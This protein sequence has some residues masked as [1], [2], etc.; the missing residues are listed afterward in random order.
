MS[1]SSAC[2]TST[3]GSPSES[4]SR[5]TML[6][7]ADSFPNFSETFIADHVKLMSEAGWSVTLLVRQLHPGFSEAAA[8]LGD[9][10]IVQVAPPTL[11]AYGQALSWMARNPWC[12]ANTLMWRCALHG[13]RLAAS[14]VP[15]QQWDVVHAH[16]G[17]NGVSALIA[18]TKWLERLTVNFH[19][20]DVT[21]V[22]TRHGWAAY[23][24]VL[25]RCHAVAHST[26][27]E[28]RLKNATELQVHPVTMGVDLTRFEPPH[29]ALCWPRPLR[30]LCVGRLTSQKGHN[31]AID[32][33]HWLREHHPEF[34]AQLTI[35]GDGPERCHLESQA[36][37]L[38]VAE[39]VGILKARPNVDMPK[40]YS[41]MDILLVPSQPTQDGQQEAFSRVSIEAMACGVP[42]VGCASGGL[43]DTIGPG[44]VIPQGFDGIAMAK[45]VL[46]LMRLNGPDAWATLARRRAMKFSLAQMAAEYG[47][48][49]DLVAAGAGNS[50]VG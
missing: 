47:A 30:L 43:P 9:S 19:G 22:P 4:L 11:R 35:V 7:L 20:Y 38:A 45:A 46:E 3:A 17:N 15:R 13:A 36:K 16:Y 41:L 10:R 18:E 21:S 25:G 2:T 24:H 14:Q 28:D 26:F 48:L 6:V 5:R 49:A 50:D 29:K 32:A 42:V 39:H 1:P 33:L 40:L 27:V 34:D 44:G 12:W 37:E 31:A 8:L 23:R